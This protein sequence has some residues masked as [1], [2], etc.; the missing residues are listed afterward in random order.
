MGQTYERGDEPNRI[1]ALGT[2]FNIVD[3]LRDLGRVGVSE[4]AAH[5]D[6]PKST[7]HVYLQTLEEEG[8]AVN[9]DGTYRLSFRFLEIGGE[10]RKRLDVFQVART[11]IDQ[12]SAET[13]EVANLGIEDRGQRVLLYTSEPSEGMFDN[14]PTGQYTRMHW[15]ALG[16]ALL[17]RF[18]DD[19]VRDIAD[20]HGLPRATEST[21]TELDPLL[22][23]L[24][25][26][27][28]RGFS[29]E[30]EERR[31]GIRAVAVPLRLDDESGPPAAVSIS[32]PKRRIGDDGV[33]E[34]LLEALRD[35]VNVVELEYKHY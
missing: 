17:S 27:R 16:K 8:Y 5:L 28:E 2:T 24:E 4:L 20:E 1:N 3:A 34:E 22:E 19:R 18:P 7:V 12:L 35:A 31:E 32:G 29:I 23:E 21:I 9:E 14:S 15:T 11:A 10:H 13:G 26:V 30:D 25:R 6:M 33:D